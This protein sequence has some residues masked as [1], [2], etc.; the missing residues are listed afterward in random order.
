MRDK[1]QSLEAKLTKTRRVRI[2]TAAAVAEHPS[3]H[4]ALVGD[5]YR[6][7]GR[8][9]ARECKRERGRGIYLFVCL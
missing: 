2:A 5:P 9:Q 8:E 7:E 3:S 6:K 1:L 4:S